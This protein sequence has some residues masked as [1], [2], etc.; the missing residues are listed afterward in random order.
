MIYPM[1]C[2][3]HNKYTSIC[4]LNANVKDVHSKLKTPLDEVT[5]FSTNTSRSTFTYFTVV[6]CV[7]NVMA[8]VQKPE[9]FFRR[10]GR[11][12]LIRG[13]RGG[14]QFSRLLAAEVC[15][16]AVV[17]LDTSCSE[18]VWRVLATHSIR[19]FPPSLHPYHTSPRVIT[20]QMDPST[21]SN[22]RTVR[23]ERM[24]FILAAQG[25]SLENS[26]VNYNIKTPVSFLSLISYLLH[27]AE[28]FLRS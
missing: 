21:W 7:W 20:F 9:F 27:G 22:T 8:H 13:E 16:S 24:K 12:H 1:L 5:D 6:D 28:S 19:Q 10:N 11:V 2:T 25:L 26:F 3:L 17:M 14:R 15:A 23:P 18:V 4:Y